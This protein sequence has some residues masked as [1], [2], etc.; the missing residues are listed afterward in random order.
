M[1]DMRSP[2]GGPF[3]AVTGG[4]GD[5]EQPSAG[6]RTAGASILRFCAGARPL[7]S[8]LTVRLSRRLTVAGGGAQRVRGGGGRRRQRRLLPR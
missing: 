7:R 1:A 5:P 6:R 2:L 8:L 4:P 3:P